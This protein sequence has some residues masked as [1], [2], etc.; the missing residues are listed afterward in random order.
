MHRQDILQKLANY[1]THFM[2]EAAYIAQARQY[3]RANPNCFDR[4]LLPAHMTGSAWV[5]NP[6]RTK[7]LLL[8]HGKHN[9]W[10]QPGGHA[11]SQHDILQVAL[12]ET[13]EE[14]GLPSEEI[15]PLDDRIFD[16]DVHT[17]PASHKFPMHQH[18]DIRFL[19][20]IDDTLFVPGSHESHDV[21]WVPLES[22]L[23][24]NNNRSTY[25]MVSKT[26]ELFNAQKYAALI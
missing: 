22:V 1:N 19:V 3:I 20:E 17:I 7:V 13:M 8:K 18:F 11:D 23:R 21:L 26:R 15:I 6:S 9:Q 16:V 25:R 5:V 4:D 14:S 10:F 24:F 2:D 12:R